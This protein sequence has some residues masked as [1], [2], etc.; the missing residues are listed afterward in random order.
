MSAS[1][2]A[3]VAKGGGQGSVDAS[4]AG[5]SW[6]SSPRGEAEPQELLSRAGSVVDSSSLAGGND[7]M[8]VCVT[9]LGVSHCC[10]RTRGPGVLFCLGAPLQL[11]REHDVC[12]KRGVSTAGG[13]GSELLEG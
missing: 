3:K 11:S 5:S 6:H 4:S 13:A 7:V 8:R 10:C 9:A 2:A 12:L 1:P